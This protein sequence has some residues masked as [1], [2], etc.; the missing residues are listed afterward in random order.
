MS[1]AR[2]VGYPVNLPHEG[3]QLPNSPA[4][5]GLPVEVFRPQ[6]VYAD[7]SSVC[8]DLKIWS[9]CFA[10]IWSVRWEM[11]FECGTRH[12][13]KIAMFWL[14]KSDFDGPLLKY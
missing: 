2:G 11:G 3:S 5:G 1:S 8:I 12:E 13:P 14:V 9:G 4:A 7:L 10:G 6:N